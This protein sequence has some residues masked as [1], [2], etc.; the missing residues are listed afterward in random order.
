MRRPPF[1]TTDSTGLVQDFR[2]RL[3]QEV[4]AEATRSYWLRRARVYE[5]ALP[6]PGDFTGRASRDDL[7][8]RRQRLQMVV[9]TCRQRADVAL[10]VHEDD[11]LDLIASILGEVDE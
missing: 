1:G 3:L 6:R 8:A 5:Q 4:L 11:S 7:Q 9:A 10:Y 2:S